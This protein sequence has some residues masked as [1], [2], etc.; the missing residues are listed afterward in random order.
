MPAKKSDNAYKAEEEMKTREKIQ[1]IQK[2]LPA[3]V[4]DFMRSMLHRSVLTRLGYLYDIRLFLRYLHDE[5]PAFADVPLYAVTPEMLGDLTLRDFEMYTE[6]LALY[7]KTDSDGNE[8]LDQHGLPVMNRNKEVGT[9]RKLSALRSLYKYL[10]SHGKIS[11]N[12]AANV[13]MPKIHKKPV[14]FLERH[15]IEKMFDAVTNGEGLSKRQQ[16]Y[17]ESF[18]ARDIAIVSLLLGTGIRESELIGLDMDHVDLEQ[19]SFLVTRKGGNESILYFNDDVKEALS[20]YLSVRKTIEPLPGYE[21]ALFLSS[22]RKRISARAVQ[23]LIKKYASV[24]APLKKRLSPHKMRST[25][26]TNL[27]RTTHDIYMVSQVLGH[28][29]IETTTRYTSED[30]LKEQAAAQVDW[31]KTK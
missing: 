21:N 4:A 26:A 9:A 22:Q 11:E 24:A 20:A 15:E 13:A 25:F 29:N 18:R 16:A 3:F 7:V 10:Y 27:Y 5:N 12:I 14:I 23:E 30:K 2:E 28:V 8:T 1:E 31:T 6:Y 19:K 17:N